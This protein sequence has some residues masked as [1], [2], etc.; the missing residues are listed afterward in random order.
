MYR[1]RIMAIDTLK[2]NT[3]FGRR[4]YMRYHRLSDDQRRDLERDFRR[5]PEACRKCGIDPDPLWLAD[6]IE[7]VRSGR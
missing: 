3:P 5:H 2:P 4:S 6:A 1:Q 7:D